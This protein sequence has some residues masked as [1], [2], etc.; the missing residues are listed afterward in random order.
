MSWITK[1]QYEGKEFTVTSF[2]DGDIYIERTYG[3]RWLLAI[4]QAKE[5]K[6]HIQENFDPR[7]IGEGED[8]IFVFNERPKN[9]VDALVS[10]K[11]L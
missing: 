2:S 5:N 8:D 1:I 4:Y 9:L 10:L 7:T 3:G 11:K 6:W